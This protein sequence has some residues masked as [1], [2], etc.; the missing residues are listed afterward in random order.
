M[1]KAKEEEN[2]EAMDKVMVS[3]GSGAQ[4]DQKVWHDMKERALVSLSRAIRTN[5]KK[6]NQVLNNG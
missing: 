6:S 5:N 4:G 3:I 1:N 2:L